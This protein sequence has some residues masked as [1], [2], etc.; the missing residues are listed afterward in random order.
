MAELLC[1][2]Q[3][4]NASAPAAAAG[5]VYFK[6]QTGFGES[7]GSNDVPLLFETQDFAPM[8]ASG[9]LVARRMH[10]FAEYGGSVAVRVT[11]IT[12]F[13]DVQPS[14]TIS[15]PAPEGGR[16]RKVLDVPMGKAC[17]YIRVRVEIL[18]RT[19][20]FWLHGVKLAYRPLTQSYEEI[21]GDDVG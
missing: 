1:V 8:G 6:S 5:E 10:V 13:N 14:Q 9:R 7:Y 21:A 4:D 15:L 11:P 3:A 20:P 19:G 16:V 17:T 2:G 18:S 12:D